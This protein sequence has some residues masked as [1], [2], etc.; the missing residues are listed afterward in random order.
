M[1]CSNPLPISLPEPC[2]GRTVALAPSRALK[3]RDARSILP[4]AAIE[5]IRAAIGW[6]KP[7]PLVRST[8]GRETAEQ[9]E[10]PT[11]AEASAG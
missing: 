2:I 10:T 4:A 8:E 1:R 5:N 3:E 9:D 6:Q 11:E 7:D